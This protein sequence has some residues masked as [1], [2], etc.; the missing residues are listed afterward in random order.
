M[1]R[2]GR[3]TSTSKDEMRG[4]FPFDF[5]QGQNDDASLWR[6]CELISVA[7]LEGCGLRYAFAWMGGG[8]MSGRREAII[9]KTAM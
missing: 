9:P 8:S 4:F 7:E 3:R 2:G 5:A 6:G 1:R